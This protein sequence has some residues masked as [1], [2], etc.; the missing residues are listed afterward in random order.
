MSKILITGGAG[1]I[2]TVLT[3][4]LLSKGYKVTIYDRL[5]YDGAILTPFF[6]NSNFKFIKGDILDKDS[7]GKVI[8]ENDVVIHLA[9]IVGYFAC[10]RLKM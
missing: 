10:D 6:G 5:M 3:E 4:L 9:A 8:N 2:G 7:L 1:Y